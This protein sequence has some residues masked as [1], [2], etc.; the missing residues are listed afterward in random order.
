MIYDLSLA[1]DA[2]LPVFE[3]DP[4]Y[5]LSGA[6]AIE[7]AGYA[8]SELKMST[9]GGTHIDVERHV[10]LGGRDT[11]TSPLDIFVGD[12]FVVP[13]NVA[14]GFAALPEAAFASLWR[15]AIA[16]IHTGWDKRFGNDDYLEDY[17]A[18]REEDMQ[19]LIDLG[20]KAVGT[21][22]PSFETDLSCRVHRLLL[23]AGVGLI[24]S[25]AGLEPLLNKRCFFAAAPLKLRG[26]DGSPVRAFAVV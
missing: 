15:G 18:F 19:R 4:H 25:L 2:A 5:S 21:D 9:H 26:G 24:E 16:L 7:T 6:I 17:P 14:G 23:G 8:V 1:L 3:G 12:A 22:L 10:F 20:V 11:E 13:A